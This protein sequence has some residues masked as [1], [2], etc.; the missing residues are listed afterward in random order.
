MAAGAHLRRWKPIAPREAGRAGRSSSKRPREEAGPFRPETQPHHRRQ[1]SSDVTPPRYSLGE[2]FL[3]CLALEIV[4]FDL[5]CERP[6]TL[7]RPENVHEQGPDPAHNPGFAGV[8]LSHRIGANIPEPRD[9]VPEDLLRKADF[10]FF[11]HLN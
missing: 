10:E 6:P 7:F 8:L 9:V 2:F 3:K 11:R 1:W 4:P 5:S